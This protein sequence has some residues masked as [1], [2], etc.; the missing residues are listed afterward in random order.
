MTAKARRTCGWLMATV[1][2]TGAQSAFGWGLSKVVW[3]HA[4]KPESDFQR[5]Y[6][7]CQQ[8]AA[9]NAANWGSKGNP[10]MIASDVNKCLTDIGWQ[11]VKASE[12]R[13]L[14]QS[15]IYVIECQTKL[16]S[17][18][19]ANRGEVAPAVPLAAAADAS[20]GD[21]L[22]EITGTLPPYGREATVEIRNQT[23]SSAR[24]SWDDA[25]Y[26]EL[27]NAGRV[28]HSGVEFSD[29][30]KPQLPSIIAGK[31]RMRQV[32]MPVEAIQQMRGSWIRLP[33][34]PKE[35]TFDRTSG[36]AVLSPG[37]TLETVDANVAGRLVGKD[38]R[39]LL[40]VEIGG[41]V[42]EYTLIFVIIGT[43]VRQVTQAD[44]EKETA[45]GR[46]AL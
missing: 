21:D 36:R 3:V 23:D 28:I 15:P 1:L 43:K 42:R 7:D 45:L 20:F 38:V 31:S 6:D 29:K 12:L 24:V 10:F 26:I 39:I 13:A 8:K 5:D 32:V 34:F 14:Q 17:V 46:S 27:G 25:S 4:S 44:L 41:V 37:M 16:G 18:L 19:R 11:R 30:G 33:L 2:F 40:P 35:E 9:Q 22:V